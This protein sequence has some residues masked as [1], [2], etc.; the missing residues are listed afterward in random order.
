MGGTAAVREELRTRLN[1]AGAACTRACSRLGPARQAAAERVREH[2]ISRPFSG[3][4]VQIV[5][6]VLLATGLTAVLSGWTSTQSIQRFLSQR[7]EAR[8]PE[9]LETKEQ[10]LRLWHERVRLDLHTFARGQTVS[11]NVSQLAAGAGSELARVEVRDYLAYVLDRFDHYSALV[12]LHDSGETV[13]S[14]GDVTGLSGAVR[15]QVAATGPVGSMLPLPGSRS[16]IASTRLGDDLPFTLHVRVELAYLDEILVADDPETR[17]RLIDTDGRLVASSPPSAGDEAT[18]SRPPSADRADEVRTYEN[19]L[20][21]RVVGAHR[22]IAPH[23][24][25]LVV[26]KD[27]DRAFAPVSQLVNRVLLINLMIG[28][29]LVLVAGRLGVSVVRPVRAL[30]AAAEKLATGRGTSVDLPRPR[31]ARELVVLT[32]S[33]NAMTRRLE[34]NRRELECKNE[35]LQRLSITDGLTTLFNQRHFQ[36]QLPLEVRR[37]EHNGACLALILL[38]I[39]NF[40]AVN[41]DY[42]HVA[43]DRILQS[44]AG[45]LRAQTSSTDLVAR[46]GGE[47]FAVLTHQDDIAGAAALAERI[48]NAVA[49]ET[50]SVAAAWEQA[51]EV[52][53]QVTV[54]LGVAVH[55]GDTDAL[56]EAA[57]QALYRAKRAGKNRAASAD[58]GIVAA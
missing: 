25:T 3:L 4:R 35:E 31:G 5:L 21:V 14:V 26:E 19:E 50:H 44:V 16:R 49:A 42:G 54:S 27:Y 24:W 34:E 33:F 30:S 39:D 57:D 38:D 2:T 47:E 13:L 7:I 28:A 12:M 29:L 20:G 9:V 46:Y 8:F 36:E 6:L 11:R 23:G 48:R 52:D 32:E 18:P 1:A 17:M 53:L 58:L 56:F 10:E 22:R 43:G 45:V 51:G 37:A 55:S 41:D 40:K 15:E